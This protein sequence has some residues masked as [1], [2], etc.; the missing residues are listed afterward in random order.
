MAVDVGDGSTATSR[1]RPGVVADGLACMPVTT[2]AP[3]GKESPWRLPSRSGRRFEPTAE[4]VLHP[5]LGTLAASLP[6]ARGSLLTFDEF[7]GPVG[8][9]DLVAVTRADAALYTRI[10]AGIAPVTSAAD[11]AILSTVA[12][13]RTT[14]VQTIRKCLGVT[15]GDQIERRIRRLLTTN[16]LQSCGRGYRRNPALVPLGRMYAL[17]AKVSDWQRAMAQALR[18]VRWSDAAAVVLLDPPKDLNPAREQARQLQLGLAV[19]DQWLVRPVL[20]PTTPGLRLL[21]S[22]TVVALARSGQ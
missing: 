8:M 19:R 11:A 2:A 4:R 14:T 6:G 18:Y 16:A 5:A 17:E 9:P 1:Y 3:D 7:P 13:R 20:R 15:S 12:I 21:A 22:E 10:E